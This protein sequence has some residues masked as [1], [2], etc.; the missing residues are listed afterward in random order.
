MIFLQPTDSLFTDRLC[1][2]GA[3][4]IDEG[5]GPVPGPA[6][7]TFCSIRPPVTCPSTG[8]LVQGRINVSSEVIW[9]NMVK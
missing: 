2:R 7:H 4:T 6:H 5:V 8:Q 3:G 1:I 9:T